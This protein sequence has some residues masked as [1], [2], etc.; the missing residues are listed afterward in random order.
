MIDGTP[1]GLQKQQ[2]QKITWKNFAIKFV[3]WNFYILDNLYE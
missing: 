1:Q 3:R 2:Q